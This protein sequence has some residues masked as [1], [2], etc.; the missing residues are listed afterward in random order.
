MG[1]VATLAPDQPLSPSSSPKR[2][3]LTFD[4]S[5]STIHVSILRN[6]LPVIRR[7][8]AS[9]DRKYTRALP[10]VWEKGRGWN[11]FHKRNDARMKGWGRARESASWEIHANEWR[12]AEEGN[13]GEQRRKRYD[14]GRWR[15][16]V[17]GGMKKNEVFR[18]DK[19]NECRRVKKALRKCKGPSRRALWTGGEMIVQVKRLN[20]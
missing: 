13:T 17:D 5:P 19:L 18:G 11:R 4:L 15:R 7:S 9:I 10:R 6:W 2:P 20:E 3:L 1:G 8:H 16:K 12:I 14:E